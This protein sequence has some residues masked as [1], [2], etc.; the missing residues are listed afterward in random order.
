MNLN[1]RP[2]DLTRQ[3]PSRLT[4]QQALGGAW[5]DAFDRGLSNITLSGTTGWR[6]GFAESGEEM[7]KTLRET[8]FTEWHKR[9]ADAIQAGKSPRDIE[10]IFVDT[11]DDIN[12]VVAPRSFVLRR[13]RTSPLLMKYNIQLAVLGDATKPSSPFDA[14]T[15]AI[16][17]AL[18][19]LKAALGLDN[20]IAWLKDAVKWVTDVFK[21][22]S[23]YVR[24]FINLAV[25]VFGTIADLARGGQGLFDQTVGALLHSGMTLAAAGRDA[26]RALAGTG[27][28][29]STVR[30]RIQRMASMFHD[31]YCTM[32]NGFNA[33]KYFRSFDDLFG[34]STCSST[35]GGHSWST[36]SAQNPFASMYPPAASRVSVTPAA[37]QAIE[38]LRRDA[39][40][41]R[42]STAAVGQMLGSIADGMRVAA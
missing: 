19:W 38:T 25:K 33:G 28:F 35:G 34:A 42:P 27:D 29:V 1:I 31:A 17:D 22:I 30:V 26:M 10:L 20:I 16:N 41:T 5:A 11:L 18:R 9:R 24:A 32:E 8:V 40:I 2:E 37:R 14:I 13:S 4:V 3:E 36:F 7:F 12:V 21:T 23:D 6:G 39:L 15:D